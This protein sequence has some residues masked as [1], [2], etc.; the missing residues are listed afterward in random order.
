ML[1]DECAREGDRQAVESAVVAA[2]VSKGRL[3]GAGVLIALLLPAVACSSQATSSGQPAA[4]TGQP[5]VLLTGPA[6]GAYAPLGRAL[7]KAYNARVP[8]V[9]VSATSASGPEGA[10]DNAEEV[11]QGKADLAFSRADIAYQVFQQAD[12][13]ESA[14]AH[15]RSIAVLYTNAVHFI[16]RRAS[17]ITRGEEMRGH[18]VQMSEDTGGGMLARLVVEAYG[19][20]IGEVQPI[21][22]SRRNALA[23]LRANELDVRIFASAYPLAIND[24]G[25]S[26]PLALLPLTPVAI[27]RLRSR[28]PFFKPAVIPS[29]TYNGQTG[30]IETVGIDGLLL[31]RD[32]LPEP[33]AYELT[34]ALFEALP[35]LA[36]TSKAARLIDAVNAP[37]TPVPLHRGAARYYRERGL[38]R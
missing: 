9:Q 31:C 8:G 4:P 34:K 19:L 3:L 1:L 5:I 2:P 21:P 37:A 14:S 13:G 20:D 16:V 32:S 25:P 23:R 15:L 7:A 18:R 28:S 35:E 36:E 38:F 29:G 11:E 10:A 33:V 12:A 27:D 24:V 6:G 26:S 30:D 22:A 17:G